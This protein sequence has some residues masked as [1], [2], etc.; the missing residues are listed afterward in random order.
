MITFAWPRNRVE[1]DILDFLDLV[2]FDVLNS[3]LVTKI[4]IR[5][6]L[7]L[8]RFQDLYFYNLDLVLFQA[9]HLKI[10]IFSIRYW[11]PYVILG[12]IKKSKP[13]K[14]T[15]GK[16]R[17]ANIRLTY[18]AEICRVVKENHFLDS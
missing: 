10:S 15:V 8:S 4:L 6:V 16:L 12:F 13:K 11:S 7:F 1:Q 5:N 2:H 17:I 3:L 18:K 14:N 9:I